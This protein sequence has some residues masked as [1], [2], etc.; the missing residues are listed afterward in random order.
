MI[1]YTL[2]KRFIQF[3][4]SVW[5]EIQGQFCWFIDLIAAVNSLLQW[6]K[7]NI[8]F[9][10]SNKELYEPLL[11]YSHCKI[12][13]FLKLVTG[14]STFFFFCVPQ[15]RESRWTSHEIDLWMCVCMWGSILAVHSHLLGPLNRL[16]FYDYPF[17]KIVHISYSFN[18]LH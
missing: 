12:P 2:S 15:K 1:I 18:K 13:S 11:W 4:K 8:L 16:F 9:F 17:E 6:I 14:S 7:N 3:F 5:L 10:S